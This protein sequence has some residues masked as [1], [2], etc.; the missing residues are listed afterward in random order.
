MSENSNVIEMSLNGQNLRLQT[1]PGLFS[2][3]AIDRGTLAMLG[4]VE[5]KRGMQILDLGC[6]YGFVGLYAARLAGEE[7]V[8]LSDA[9][10]IAVK[11]A[12]LNAEFNG[13]GGSIVKRE[14]PN[15]EE[16]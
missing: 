6:G 14:Q 7:N 16:I 2:P 12:R 10:P 1:A 3:K 5:F 9:D 8:Y 4:Q 11:Y 15:D 13:L